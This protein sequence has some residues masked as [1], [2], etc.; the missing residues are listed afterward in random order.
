MMTLKQYLKKTG[1]SQMQFA[2][3]LGISQPSF[4]AILSGKTKMTVERAFEIA[5]ITKGEVKVESWLVTA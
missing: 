4:N 2:K 1:T 5:E 3:A